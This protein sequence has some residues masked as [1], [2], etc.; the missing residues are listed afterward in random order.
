[1][2]LRA[3]KYKDVRSAY[4]RDI[5]LIGRLLINVFSLVILSENVQKRGLCA[6]YT[7]KHLF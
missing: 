1:M 2:L 6:T 7:Y 5:R 3:R 4:I